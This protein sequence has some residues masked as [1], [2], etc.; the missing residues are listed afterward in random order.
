[1]INYI[2]FSFC[3][4]ST[5][6]TLDSTRE[7]YD[8]SSFDTAKVI[9]ES[10]KEVNA[11]DSKLSTYSTVEKEVEEKSAEG[12]ILVGYYDK[13]ELR[14][15]VGTY[16]GETGKV[17]VEYYK[18]AGDFFYVHS[19]TFTYKVL[20]YVDPSGIIQ[21][22]EDNTYYFYKEGL[23]KWQI[24]TNDSVIASDSPE[25]MDKD[26]Y[27]RESFNNYK[28]LFSDYTVSEKEHQGDTVRCKYG[29]SC[30]STGFVIKGSRTRNGGVKHVPRP[31]KKNVPIEE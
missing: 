29:A 9:R 22:V 12:A 26:K 27:L 28:I 25:F 20:I 7:K 11:V 18:I 30:Q 31:S 21:S 24:G 6:C 14:K 5:S 13:D 15:I 19:K 2:L 4:L 1:M 8:V 3:V 23:I 16:Y 10:K 17:L